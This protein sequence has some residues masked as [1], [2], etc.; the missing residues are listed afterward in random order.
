MVTADDEEEQSV[1]ALGAAAATEGTPGPTFPAEPPFGAEFF[2][3]VLRDRVRD[4]CSDRAEELP[5][6][7]LR[8]ADGSTLDL[9]H[10]V[11]V[12][13]LWFSVQAFR[14]PETGDEMDLVF[15][16][17]ETVTRVTLSMLPQHQRPIGF[18]V[19]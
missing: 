7:Q 10:I 1:V 16:P 9:C 4:S 12:E 19:G 14:D 15:V 2:Q 18:R 8:L 6:V 11:T 17:Y 13:R 3:T 5:V